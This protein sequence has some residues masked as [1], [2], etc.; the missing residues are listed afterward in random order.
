MKDLLK[1]R[2][3]TTMDDVNSQLGAYGK[4]IFIRPTGFGKTWL[5]VEELAKKYKV[6]K[7]E[8]LKHTIL[9]SSD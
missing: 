2:Q 6:T 8:F 5:L 1:V 7:E 4:S 3:R 9:L